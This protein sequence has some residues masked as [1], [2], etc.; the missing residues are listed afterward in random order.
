MR[1]HFFSALI[2]LAAILSLCATPARA[3][4]L[5]DKGGYRWIGHVRYSGVTYEVEL[6]DGRTKEFHASDVQSVEWRCETFK[7]KYR[8][9][10]QVVNG[11]IVA[12]WGQRIDVDVFDAA[13][14]CV[15]TMSLYHK[16]NRTDSPS[17]DGHTMS[18]PVPKPGAYIVKVMVYK[19]CEDPNPA[20][21]KLLPPVHCTRDTTLEQKLA[22]IAKQGW[23]VGKR[24][25]T[26]YGWQARIKEIVPVEPD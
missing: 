17:L 11:E 18:L 25:T 23:A 22:V 14:R 1:T 16:G 12:H 7:S 26:D 3:D 8:I 6:A 10:V 21:I 5:I 24:Y 19:W 20:T 13:G 9:D 15:N 4:V 2:L